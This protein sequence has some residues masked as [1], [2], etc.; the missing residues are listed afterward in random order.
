[1]VRFMMLTF[2]VLGWAFYELSGGADFVPETVKTD[3]RVE[4]N[5][6]ARADISAA[7][8]LS[9][10][11]ANGNASS[12]IAP[13]QAAQ[14]EG[15]RLASFSPVMPA[16]LTRQVKANHTRRATTLVRLDVRRPAVDAEIATPAVSDAAMEIRAVN[17]D[18]V[19]M[20]DGPGTNFSVL[21]SLGRGVAVEVL[22]ETGDGWVKLRVADTGRVGW[23]ADFLLSSAD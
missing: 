13:R 19:N 3:P 21:G 22:Q 11:P 17:G 2:A 10:A 20:R 1:M 14:S 23:M 15:A 7:E 8:L 12:I 9:V 16:E 6:V 18:R 4:M 5:T